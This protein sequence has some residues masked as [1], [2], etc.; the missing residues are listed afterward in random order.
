M[1]LYVQYSNSKN[2]Q[3]WLY[4]T[5]NYIGINSTLNINIKDFYNNIFNINTCNTTGLNLWGQILNTPRN[6]YIGTAPKTFGF[7]VNP[8]NTVDYAQNFNHG[9]F[10]SGGLWTTLPDGEYRCLLMLRAR[11]FISN[12][13]ILSITKLL[14]EFFLN[15]QGYANNTENYQFSVSVSVDNFTHNQLNYIFKD[16]SIAPTGKLPIWITNIFSITNISVNAF[17]LPLPIGTYPNITITS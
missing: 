16:L 15:L 7:N 5:N 8:H 12:M 1:T 13:S 11:T 2:F 3:N 6:F 17:Y 9:T 10:Y 4:G 14:N